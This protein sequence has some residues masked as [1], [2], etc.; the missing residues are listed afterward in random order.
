[1]GFMAHVDTCESAYG[2]MQVASA[3]GGNLLLR[4]GDDEVEREIVAVIEGYLVKFPAKVVGRDT[5]E[6]GRFYNPASIAIDS[7]TGEFFVPS[8]RP[9]K[10]SENEPDI[11]S[12]PM[13]ML[14]YD[15]TKAAP[16]S[17]FLGILKRK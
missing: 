6:A 15:G 2:A 13:D 16:L 7:K 3:V 1:M 4:G 10:E 12:L 11:F 9:P 8:K 17:F 5:L 14:N